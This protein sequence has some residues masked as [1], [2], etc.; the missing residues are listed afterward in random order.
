M[1]FYKIIPFRYLNIYKECIENIVSNFEMEH[2]DYIEYF[3]YFHYIVLIKIHNLFHFITSQGSFNSIII[4]LCKNKVY[5][6]FYL[7]NLFYS[8]L[9]QM[10]CVKLKLQSMKRIS[11]TAVLTKMTTI[12]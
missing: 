9:E 12:P 1:K 6:C 5:E 3:Y 2:D 8:I 10:D 7:F 4:P 11:T